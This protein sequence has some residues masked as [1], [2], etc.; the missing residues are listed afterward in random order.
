MT[1]E[2]HPLYHTWKNIRR[3]CF[4]P[5]CPNFQYYGERGITMY[6]EWVTTKRG[7]ASGEAFRRFAAWVDQELGPRPEGCSIDRIDTDGNYEPG[8]LRWATPSEQCFNRRPYTHKEKPLKYAQR[9][10]SGWA[11]TF[12]LKGTRHYV[13]HFD[14]PEKASTAARAARE[15]LLLG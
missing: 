13:G 9:T 12:K 11:A 2:K 4:D 8:N 10:K 1:N 3:R 5:K 7:R 14:S 6:P 15:N